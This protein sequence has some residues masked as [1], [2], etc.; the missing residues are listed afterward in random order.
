M[1]KRG[2]VN[3]FALTKRVEI[4]ADQNQKE[5][6]SC[7]Q[8]GICCRW[9]GHVLLTEEDIAQLAA[10]MEISEEVFIGSYTV[11]AA[12]RRQLSLAEHPDG[13]CVFLVEN[14]CRYYAARPSQCRTFPHAWRVAEGCPAL[15]EMDKGNLKR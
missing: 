13:R 11:L 10:V 1:F 4:M 15:E 3:P 12:N 9:E 8:C 5:E 6:F 7:Q 2:D 14:Q